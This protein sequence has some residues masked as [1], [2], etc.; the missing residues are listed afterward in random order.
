VATYFLIQS[1]ILNEEVESLLWSNHAQQVMNTG[2]NLLA[3]TLARQAVENNNNLTL[4]AGLPLVDI[5]APPLSQRVLSAAG[6]LPGARQRLTEHNASIWAMDSYGTLNGDWRAVS[7]DASGLVNIWNLQGD[8]PEATRLGTHNSSVWA[9]A[10]S[11]DGTAAV[12]ASADGTLSMWNTV[13]L[14][15]RWTVETPDIVW[16]VAFSRDGDYLLTGDLSGALVLRSAETGEEL[17]RLVE[18]NGAIWA[19]A[20]SPTGDFVASGGAGGV[21]NLN[22]IVDGALVN[23]PRSLKVNTGLGR[24]AIWSLVFSSNGQQL[25]AGLEDRRVLM[26]NTGQFQLVDTLEGHNDRVVSLAFTPSDETDALISGAADGDIFI[27]NMRTTTLQRRFRSHDGAVWALNFSP[28]ARR[29]L[30]ASA[31]NSLIIWDRFSG[32]QAGE[33][34]SLNDSV[35]AMAISMQNDDS[36]Q[37]YLAAST[38]NGSIYIMRPDEEMLLL[39]VLPEDVTDLAFSPTRPDQLAAASHDAI[40]HIWNRMGRLSNSVRYQGHRDRLW[41]VD[42]HSEGRYIVTGSAD[43]SAIIWDV[44]RTEPFVRLTNGETDR[45]VITNGHLDE[46]LAAK[47]VP[48]R[49]NLTVLTGGA[50]NRLLL[51]QLDAENNVVAPL[52]LTRPDGSPA[53]ENDVQS[54]AISPDGRHAL[55]GGADDTVVLWN[56]ESGQFVDELSSE[57]TDAVNDI[58]FVPPADEATG[59]SSYLAVT[60]GSDGQVLTWELEGDSRPELL[61]AYDQNAGL[62]SVTYDPVRRIIYTGSDTGYIIPWRLDTL[63]GLLAWIDENRRADALS[64]D[65]CQ[66]YSPEPNVDCEQPPGSPDTT[67]TLLPANPNVQSSER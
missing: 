30:S 47:F 51:W 58:L 43:Q 41:S 13:T 24:N 60:V 2:D 21:I 29:M 28:D 59:Q 20:A 26:I 16:S 15:R 46:V 5:E 34:I 31:D 53:H 7:G 45:E 42:Y 36:G 37:A 12:T 6:Y 50:D 25:A 48:G 8:N 64:P 35:T 56:L 17:D 9:V 49:D 14:V 38:R 39:D 1:Q 10:M 33:E 63:D 66:R 11:A 57:H 27:W 52:E 32:A 40:L 61:R 44:G 65:E 23:L 22:Q 62:L 67:N 55:S 18:H 4:L 3:V 54:L 19:V